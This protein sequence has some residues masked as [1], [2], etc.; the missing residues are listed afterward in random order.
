VRKLNRVVELLALAAVVFVGRP[1]TALAQVPTFSVVQQPMQISITGPNAGNSATVTISESGASSWRVASANTGGGGNW[2]CPTIS[3]STMTVN[4]GSLCT[5]NS[6]SLAANTNY[7]GVINVQ[8]LDSGGNPVGTTGNLQV[9]L[10]VSNASGGNGLVAS[11]NPVPFSGSS[12]QQQT[13]TVSLNGVQQTIS[14]ISSVATSTG[15][16]WLQA[17]NQTNSVLISVFPANLTFGSGSDTGT[18]IVNTSGGT[19]TIT[20]TLSVSGGTSGLVATPNPLTLTAQVGSNSIQQGTVNITN[21]GS[22]VGISSVTSNQNWLQAFN[23]GNGAVTVNANPSGLSGNNSGLVT[24]ITS[25]GTSISFTVNFNVG[26]GGTSGLVANPNPLTINLGFGAASTTQNVSITYNGSLATI[27]GVSAST[28]TGQNWIQAFSQNQGS[29]SVTV[30]PTNLSGNYFGTVTVSTTNGTVQFQVNLTVGTGNTSGLVASPTVINFNIALLGSGAPSQTVNV[31][32]NGAPVQINSLST[33]VNGTWL[34]PSITNVGVVTV[35]FNGSSLT[36]GSYSGTVTANTNSGSVTFQVNANVGQGGGS[37]GLAVTPNPLPVNLPIGSGTNTQN[38]SV[39]FNGSP[40]TV[41]SVSTS[42]TTGQNWLQASTTGITGGVAVTVNPSILPAGNYSG[43]VLINTVSGQVNLVVNLALGTGGTT[44][45]TVTPSVVT[46]TSTSGGTTTPQNVSVTLNGNPVTINSLTSTTT[47]GQNWLFPSFSPSVPGTVTVNTSLASLAAG[48]YSGTVTVNTL[49]GTVSF[50]VTLS[51][52]GGTTGN[53]LIATPNPVSFTESSPGAAGPQIVSV[54]LN[55]AAQPI[56]TATFAPSLPGLTFLNTVINS[57]GTATFT[58]N[59][60]VS[61]QGTYTG[62]LTLY[63]TSGGSIGVPVILTF[64]TGGGGTGGLAASPSVVNFNVQPGTSPTTQNVSITFN[65]SLATI[66]S[67]NT[68][69]T[70]GQNWLQAAN[71]GALGALTVTANPFGLGSGSYTGTVTVITTSGSLS[72]PVNLTV[73]G[74]GQST[75]TLSTTALNFA[76]QVGQDQPPSQSVTLTATGGAQIPFTAAAST[77]TSASWL[78]IVPTS[79]TVGSGVAPSSITA[80]VNASGLA[81]GTYTGTISIFPS[82]GATQTVTVTLTVTPAPVAPTPQVVA[83]QNAASSIPT[84]LSPGLNI[85][86]F[87]SNLGPA[88]LTPFVVGANGALSTSVAGTQVMFDGIAAPIIYTRNTLVSVMV[89]YEIAGRVSTAMVV[90]YNGASSTALQLRV[91]DT[92]PG[93]Y[94]LNSTGSGQAAVI[95]QNGTVNSAANPEVAG[96]YL[97]IYVTGEGQTSPA[98]VD[99][100]VMPSRLPLPAPNAAVTVT[101]GNVLVP[102]TDINYAGEAPSLVSGVMQVNAKIPVG[103]GPGAVPLVVRVGGVASQANV[104]VSVR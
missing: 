3:G 75:I 36:M 13:V 5:G 12:N 50:Q 27:I 44:G 72:L 91:V 96:N 15:S 81:A 9:L 93:I 87:G 69:T 97:Q 89:P 37:T 53:G 26:T 62:T 35:S 104:T 94:T 57:D 78:S 47:T 23:S 88:T 19:L 92:A 39:T 54:T 76:Y 103:V 95:N 100:A 58:V 1:D 64:G 8:G 74:T 71:S 85:L 11:Q 56:L 83:I 70:T 31:T 7:N 52:G 20:V 34:L 28:T 67:V 32:Y 18:V 82:G 21:N 14:N 43:S 60:V 98:G 63:L 61:A 84:S 86:I 59:N 2:L 90:T 65:G 30:N 99:G 33:N 102:A 55:G 6:T 79:G 41:N 17:T 101:I 16:A 73:G 51:V 46:L 22:A 77:S 45:L 29:V 24:V 10:Q 48:T 4:V 66:S 42:T 40:L 80:S 68:N 38:V 25:L 49:S